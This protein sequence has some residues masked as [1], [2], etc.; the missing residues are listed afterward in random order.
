M[1][2]AQ[3]PAQGSNSSFPTRLRSS[4]STPSTR[5]RVAAAARLLL[6][7]RD[8]T[9]TGLLPGPSLLLPN[10][11]R[12]SLSFRCYCFLG[13][14]GPTPADRPVLPDPGVSHHA[15]AV[16]SEVVRLYRLFPLSWCLLACLYRLGCP[17]TPSCAMKNHVDTSLREL[18]G[19]WPPAHDERPLKNR[20]L[21]QS[22]PVP[23]GLVMRS[24]HPTCPSFFSPRPCRA[25]R[26]R[27]IL[28]PT[29]Q[30]RQTRTWPRTAPREAPF[31][32]ASK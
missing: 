25:L 14:V 13:V 12:H 22:V 1:G 20:D 6:A 27:A 32:E 17:P 30:G 11:P 19:L 4:N 18:L 21:S 28:W 8:P 9:N 23:A 7:R 16:S 5:A 26:H 2:R 31:Y 15:R 3:Q 24:T 10:P 29:W